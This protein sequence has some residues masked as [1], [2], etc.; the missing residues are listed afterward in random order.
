M[1]TFV[2]KVVHNKKKEYLILLVILSILASFEFCFI[3]MYNTLTHIIDNNILFM[4]MSIIPALTLGVA[5]VLSVFIT[6]YFIYNQQKEFSMLLL[7]GR[8]PKELFQYLLIQYGILLLIAFVIGIILGYCLMILINS[9]LISIHI[10]FL[11]EY[12]FIETCLLYIPFL[13]F[14]ILF[15]LAISAR[16]FNVID[17]DVVSTLNNKTYKKV[18]PYKIS[19]SRHFGDRK[20]PVVSIIGLL[21]SLYIMFYSIYAIFVDP[22]LD[23]KLVFFMFMFA[24]IISVI[25]I[26]IPLIFDI[27]H[28]RISR[29]PFLF[30]GISS[31]MDLYVEL[32]SIANIHSIIVPTLLILLILASYSEIMKALII[33]SFIML[34]LMVVMC[35]IIKYNIYLKN[36]QKC[37]AIQ[38]AL[39][40]DCKTIQN[41][42]LFKNIIFFIFIIIIPF[43]FI[44]YLGSLITSL[45]YL[46]CQLMMILELSYIILYLILMIYV[47]H[48]EKQAIKEV[49]ENVKYLNRSE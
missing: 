5:V 36:T 14:T 42:S 47:T 20:V 44:M 15:I 24:G 13:I 18:I 46:S 4:S 40:F 43:L 23:N 17:I 29:H 1:F 39:G 31:F 8:T 45:G 16:Q 49:T 48:K 33:P 25:N 27:F 37:Y 21:F 11:Y 22:L 9:I 6:K 2:K 35:F 41:I 19:M 28:E 7:F 12:S 32:V 34:L 26:F 30:H 38:Y 3:A 10:Q